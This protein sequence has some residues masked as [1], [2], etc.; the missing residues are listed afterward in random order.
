MYLF[1]SYCGVRLEY[2]AVWY[3]GENAVEDSTASTLAWRMLLNSWYPP[4]RQKGVNMYHANTKL[5]LS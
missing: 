3:D 5:Q 1:L 4:T 2:C